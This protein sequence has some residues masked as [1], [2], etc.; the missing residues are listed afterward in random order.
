[1][2]E[3]ACVDMCGYACVCAYVSMYISVRVGM[4]DYAFVGTCGYA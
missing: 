2:H 4:Y 1:M 3:H